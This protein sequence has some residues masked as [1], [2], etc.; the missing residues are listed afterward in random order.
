MNFR[1]LHGLRVVES[2]A[3]IAAPLAGMT[4]AQFGADVIRIDMPGGGIDYARLPVM[5]GGRSL[6]W[7]GL[8]KGKRS[9]AVDIRRP[10]GKEL[11]R[12][13]A[14]RKGD[15]AG[16][17]LTN[18]GAPWLS[19]A[20]LAA[21]R[22]DVITCTIEGNP[23]GTTAVDYTVNC[24]AGF[25]AMTGSGSIT[26]P[27]NHVLPAWDIACAYQAAFAVAAAWASRRASGTGA[28]IRIALSDVAFA[29]LSHL[30]MSAEAELLGL[31]RPSIGNYLFGAFGRDF[32]TRDGRR[33]FVAA[34]SLNQW[35]SLVAACEIES[36]IGEL[37]TS[38]R[39][40]FTKEGDR[41]LAREPIAVL[42][43]AWT[44]ARSLVEVVE[45]FNRR[46]VCWGPY[47]TVREALEKDPRIS[48][49]NPV[50]ERIDTAGVGQHLA[51]GTPI[52]I[53]D[54]PRGAVEPAPL[55]G[56][57]T[58]QVLMDVLHLDSATVGRLHDAGIVAGP[59]RD[60]FVASRQART[61]ERSAGEE[62]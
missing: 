62:R 52:R 49:A 26:A 55:L 1:L 5:P 51:A 34:I 14:T 11:V 36:S 40:D 32:A 41:Y 58:D 47:Q 38:L 16:V 10:E 7:T 9:F 48:E 37:E 53:T 56:Q 59:E 24:A 23:D 35:K 57:H 42:V 46:G 44:T 61:M 45:I 29:M 12:E 20:S 39:M 31:E 6:Y 8:N 43:E 22:R 18:L 54:V 13:L 21:V 25:P 3:F 30:G 2:S 60:P 19:H 15:D 4:L 27:V 33:V 28:E 50:F 17:L